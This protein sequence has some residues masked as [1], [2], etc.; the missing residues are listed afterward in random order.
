MCQTFL[1]LMAPNGRIVNISSVGSSLQPYQE[2]VRERFRNPNM[3]LIDLEDLAQEF[4]QSVQNGTENKSGFGEPRR[5]YSVS[6]A[7]VNAFTRI[8]AKDN[9][10]LVINA[11]CPGWVNT[12]MG[13]LVGNRTPPKE[14]IDGA[15]I[16]YK[17]AFESIDDVTGAYWANSNV[18]SKETGHVQEW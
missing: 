14:P 3:T 11:C 7:C 15:A 4:E 9:P 16:P 13:H 5:S 6:K 8:L 2:H 12:D 17:L 18:R 10:G 1:P